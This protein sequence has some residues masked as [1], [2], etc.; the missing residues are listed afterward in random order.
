MRQ[1]FD[2]CFVSY[3]KCGATWTRL[4]LGKYVQLLANAE[5]LPLFDGSEY[6]PKLVEIG[7]PRMIFTHEPLT[8]DQQKASDLTIDTTIA[9]FLNA[10]VVLITRYPLDALVSGQ[11]QWR[12]QLNAAVPD[13]IS[14]MDDPVFGLEKLLAF[15]SLWAANR[16]R[17]KAFF[18]LRYEDM[19]RATATEMCRLLDFVGLPSRED[20]LE[21]AISF[22]SFSNLQKLQLS[23]EVPIYPASGFKV[24]GPIDASNP[25]SFRVRRGVAGGYRSDLP[26]ADC[27]ILEQRIADRMDPLFG[28]Q[29]PPAR[30]GAESDGR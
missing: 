29:I 11:A 9:P 21:D 13:L 24:F 23:Q 4:L 25:Q 5:T 19:R 14:F 26:A 18:L 17:V 27:A 6:E 15:H 16:N 20:L 10:K 30:P 8:W 28:Y 1:A 22:A 7:T 2:V 3:P 12:H